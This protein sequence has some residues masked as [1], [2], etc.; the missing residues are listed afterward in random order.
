M[1]RRRMAL[2]LMARSLE[3]RPRAGRAD[4]SP[5]RLRC[6]DGE[7]FDAKEFSCVSP[8]FR[9]A[10]P[11]SSNSTELSYCWPPLERVRIHWNVPADRSLRFRWEVQSAGEGAPMR[12]LL[13]SLV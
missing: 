9:A 6:R 3:N 8:S 4:R 13:A 5:V 7:R 1:G 11:Q 10:V 12:T 2:S